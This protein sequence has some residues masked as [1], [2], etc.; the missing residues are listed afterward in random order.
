MSKYEKNKILSNTYIIVIL[1]WQLL[2]FC[3]IFLRSFCNLK[4]C[5]SDSF[6]VVFWFPPFSALPLLESTTIMNLASP[7]SS[8]LF[9]FV[10]GVHWAVHMFLCSYQFGIFF[11]H[12]LSKCFPALV[13]LSSPGSYMWDHFILSLGLCSLSLQHVYLLLSISPS[14]SSLIFSSAVSN[15]L[16]SPSD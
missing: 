11:S 16:L 13:Y 2:T 4:R 6:Q 9:V 3:L 14:L 12:Y 1:N 7:F 10:L 15:Q 5:F 8:F